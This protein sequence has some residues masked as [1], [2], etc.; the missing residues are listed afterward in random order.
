MGACSTIPAQGPGGG[1][2]ICWCKAQWLI[3]SPFITTWE[4]EIATPDFYRKAKFP[5]ARK[6][7]L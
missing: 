1:R 7:P 3:V 6:Q 5:S 4:T 2:E